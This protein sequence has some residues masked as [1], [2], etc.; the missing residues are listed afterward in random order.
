MTGGE[1]GAFITVTASWETEHLSPLLWREVPFTGG[2][3]VVLGVCLGLRRRGGGQW[4]S[5]CDGMDL[6]PLAV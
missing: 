4:P 1:G 3:V 2:F 6:P 5:G